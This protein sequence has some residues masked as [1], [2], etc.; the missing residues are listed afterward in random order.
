MNEKSLLEPA[1][2]NLLIIDDDP[3]TI[4]FFSCLLKEEGY[5]VCCAFNAKAALETLKIKL[6]DLILLDVKLTDMDGFEFCQ[7]LKASTHYRKIPV[8]FIT[9]LEKTFEKVKG[10]QV[11]AVDYITK[12]FALEEV[13]ARVKT[14]LTIRL[15]QKHFEIQNTQLGQELLAHEHFEEKL[16]Q[17]VERRTKELAKANN[18]LQREI[19]E[20]K[21]IEK[22][23]RESE[24]NLRTFFNTI[25]DLF[26]V[27]DQNGYIIK[28]NTTVTTRLGYTEEELLGKN[29]LQVHPKE[30]WEE[31]KQIIGDMI[32]GKVIF[33][34]IPLITK[35][36]KCIPVE[37]RVVQGTWSGQKVLFG[38]CKD[39]S[40]IKAEEEKFSLAFHASPAVMAISR[41]EDGCYIDVNEA[42]LNTLGYE[43]DEVI[44]KTSVALGLYANIEQRNHVAQK[45]KTKGSLRNFEMA[46]HTKNGELRNGLFSADIIQ[47]QEQ[48]CLLTVMKDITERK[49]AE[50]TLIEAKEAAEAAT[51]AKSEF[52]AN[53]SHEIRTPMNGIIGL[54]QLALKTKMTPQQQ[55]YL[56]QIESSAQSLRNI[57]N[58]ILDFSKIEAG[59]LTLKHINFYLND[60]LDKIS[61]LLGLKIEEKGLN[62][63][64]TTAQDVPRYLV[65]DPLRL[66]Q[67]LLNLTTNAVKFTKQGEIVIKTNLVKLETT[68]VKLRFSVRDTGIGIPQ[69]KTSKLFK[70]FTQVDSTATRHFGGTGLGLVIC[71]R[72]TEMM[73]GEIGFESQPGKGSTFSFT[74]VFGRGAPTI[75]F[76]MPPEMCN[77]KVLIVDNNELSQK[78]LQEQLS[79]FSFNISSANSGEAALAKLETDIH[80]DLVL[81]NLPDSAETAKCIK[82]QFQHPMIIAF[83]QQTTLRYFD[84]ILIKP[85]T[86]STLFDS[87]I[88]VFCKKVAK[89]SHRLRTPIAEN[90][91]ENIQGA[92]ILLAEDNVIN[93]QVARE[94]L[95]NAYLV[96]EIANNGKEAIA[97]LAKTEFDAVLMD[98]Q[99]PEMD[100]FEATR[101]IRKNAQYQELPIIAM[102]AHAMMGYREKCLIAGMN[103]Y[104]TKP[105]DVDQLFFAL[106]KWIKLK[107]RT[108]PCI[109]RD[110]K[111][112]T[113]PDKLPGIDINSALKRLGGNRK[114]FKKLLKDFYQ[115]NQN[116]ALDIRTAFDKKDLET[117]LR[118]SHTL[119]GITGNLSATQLEGRVRDLETTL[120]QGVWDKVLMDKVEISLVQ[121]LETILTL[122]PDTYEE[123]NPTPLDISVVTPLLNKLAKQI[124]KYSASAEDTLK[125]L[126]TH[127]AGNGFTEELKQL[128]ESLNIFDFKSAQIPLNAI[129]RALNVVLPVEN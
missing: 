101:L 123:I 75:N 13:L 17:Q 69:E 83:G 76:Q 112:E 88:E 4:R 59:K 34:P 95:E 89:T 85:V 61:C 1:K 86:L 16:E 32:A 20:R 27:L 54:T 66:T 65:G 73:G 111:D 113:L 94:M 40:E 51:K 3:V 12:P 100:G 31:A 19:E 24:L 81:L 42:F 122:P 22:A 114:L 33:C 41:L 97:M 84:A 28:I 46:I 118:L 127:L 6:P 52:L 105:V 8:I 44:G 39:I 57:I 79:T 109:K 103:D 5:N 98:V 70:A 35:K 11:G 62:L 58:D 37:T 47:L 106:G 80:Y 91:I 121:L 26:F 78:N 38:V 82:A 23:L 55:A 116:V 48:T 9:V 29:V 53:M 21:Q 87:I 25:D 64:L 115:D 2:G 68:Q 120:K 128:S 49:Q 56:S 67:I 14:H 36:G 72:L 124:G 119:K 77:L 99:M 126:K 107:K 92:R 110:T 60:V 129:A 18:A 104:V 93:Q 10:F 43:K 7:Q 45:I 15:I 108:K 102:T 125:I 71:K 74:A 96:V 117:A 30:R 63:F 50:Q 90:I